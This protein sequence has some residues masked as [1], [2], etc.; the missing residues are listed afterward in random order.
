MGKSEIKGRLKGVRNLSDSYLLHSRAPLFN[1]SHMYN[2]KFY[3]SHIKKI[4]T[5]EMNFGIL[6]LTHY[7]QNNVSTCNQYINY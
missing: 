2:F 3:S 1:I 6:Y 4:E 5:G 7:S